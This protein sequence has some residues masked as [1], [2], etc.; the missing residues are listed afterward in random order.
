MVPPKAGAPVPHSRLA[1]LQEMAGTTLSRNLK[2]LV[3]DGLVVIEQGKDRRTRH[4]AITPEGQFALERARPL[5]QSV[6]ERVV[7]EVGQDR[8][9]R[10]LE[11]LAELTARVRR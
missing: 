9:D 1:V 3:R 4:V 2:P 8:V 11:E 10:L 7:A 5:W 6:Q